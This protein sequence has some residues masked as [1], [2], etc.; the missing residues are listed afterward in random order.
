MPIQIKIKSSGAD[1]SEYGPTSDVTSADGN[2]DDKPVDKDDVSI[3]DKP[4][5]ADNPAVSE[6]TA[7]TGDKS[8][9]IDAKSA[10]ST[11]KS[12]ASDK[13]SESAGYTSAEQIVPEINYE[14]EGEDVYYTDQQTKG[15]ILYYLYKCILNNI[16]RDG[17]K[18]VLK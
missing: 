5:A 2:K 16:T 12:A 6:L 13:D 8:A 10:D 1:I 14:Y 18:Y 17:K 15:T 7:A 11:D 9:L 3:D 4:P